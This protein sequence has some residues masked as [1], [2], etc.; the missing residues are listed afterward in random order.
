MTIPTT[1]FPWHQQQWQ[2]VNDMSSQQRL[3]HA[4]LIGGVP[5]LA[6]MAFAQ[7]LAA[8]LLCQAPVNGDACNTCKPCQ[9]MRAQSHPDF[10]LLQPEEVGKAILVDQVRRL[11]AKLGTTAQQGGARVVVI[12]GATDLNLNGANALL[13][14]LEEPGDNCYFLLIHQWP[15]PVLPT[16]RSRCQLL[17]MALPD[18]SS[19]LTWLHHEASTSGSTDADK[20]DLES[21]TQVLHLAKGAPLKALELYNNKAHEMRH[22]LL[23]ELTA[24]LRGKQTSVQVA[25]KWHKLPLVQVFTWWV[26]WLN[27][28][29]KYKLTQ[30]VAAVE[31]PDLVKLLQAVAQRSDIAAIYHLLGEVTQQLNYIHQRRNLNPQLVCEDLLNGWFLMV[32]TGAKS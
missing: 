31:N 5:G 27:D 30:D 28:L 22:Q 6:K 17:D 3:P 21:F 7:R 26:E 24:I 32:R 8:A 23:V 2:Q 4:L 29:V 11:Q 20:D 1:S 16:I 12:N 9:L 15:K 13:K 25:E 10:H 14:Q 18:T 19:A